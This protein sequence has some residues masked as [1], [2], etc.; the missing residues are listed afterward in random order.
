MR[1]TGAAA[2]VSLFIALAADLAAQSPQ[3]AA[4]EAVHALEATAREL[5]LDAPLGRHDL[6]VLNLPDEFVRRVADR[7]M[8]TAYQER[9][10]VVLRDTPAA[11]PETAPAPNDEERGAA[12]A[13]Q[14]AGERRSV[15]LLAA[16]AVG[17]A[18]AAAVIFL[19]RRRSR[20]A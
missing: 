1:W 17:L 4:P 20:A 10:H 5:V 11:N 19:R 8:R 7:Q 2:A 3:P 6:R 9:N 13:S 14:P 18:A 15:M 16:P 12:Q